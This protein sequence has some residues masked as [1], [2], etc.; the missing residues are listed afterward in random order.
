VSFRLGLVPAA[1]DETLLAEAEAAAVAADAAIVVVGSAELT[2]SEGF[3]R[4]TLALPGRQDELVR[5]V[6]AINPATI[7]VVN[8]GMP[9]L[10]P[11]AGQVA[12]I[13]HAWM[14]GQAFGDAL[15]DVLLGAAEPGGR[16]PVTFPATEADAP[17]LHA[18]PAQDDALD[19]AEGLLVGYRGYDASGTAPRYPFGHGLGYTGWA[20]ESA[21]CPAS[22]A[23][24]EDLEIAVTVKNT[25]QRPGKEVIQ[26]Y[27]AGP[28]QAGP[29][30]RPHRVLAAFAVVRAEPGERV[31][32]RLTIPARAFARY[33]E[34]LASWIWPGGE[35]TVHVGRSSRDLPLSAVV[36]LRSQSPDQSLEE[37]AVG[38]RR[39]LREHEPLELE[40]D[41]AVHPAPDLLRRLH[42]I[43]GGEQASG[44]RQLHRAHQRPERRARVLLGLR[45]L[46][47][48]RDRVLEHDRVEVGVG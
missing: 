33:D 2:E 30:P 1:D 15:A 37:R 3:D 47:L 32:A 46:V 24:G 40:R 45:R 4:T 5:R 23:E 22:L 38:G 17:V 14:P 25:G 16:L 11:W 19:Y 7:V 12:A 39:I 42:G 21:D 13:V 31:T 36:R 44:R 8:S 26:A 20:Y 41:R 35:W 27:L 48:V 18:T 29:V 28:D 34:D 43:G 6:A 9:V 10:T